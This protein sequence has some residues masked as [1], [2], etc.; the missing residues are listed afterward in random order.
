MN[1]TVERPVTVYVYDRGRTRLERC[2]HNTGGDTRAGR[3]TILEHYTMSRYLS[4]M[5]RVIAN[6]GT[7]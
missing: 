6:S 2:A 4:T 1:N 5:K 7:I 3:G